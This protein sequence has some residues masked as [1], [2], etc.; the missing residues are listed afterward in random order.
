MTQTRASS[1]RTR[2]EIPSHASRTHST[3]NGLTAYP[4]RKRALV[5]H[6]HQDAMPPTETGAATVSESVPTPALPHHASFSTRVTSIPNDDDRL[7]GNST[8]D[9]EG[10][11]DIDEDEIQ[12]SSM[13]KKLASEIPVITLP[14]QQT[15]QPQ[16]T[17]VPLTVTT[18][19]TTP[20][21]V[22]AP[23]SWAVDTNIVFNSALKNGHIRLK[24]QNRRVEAVFRE[25]MPSIFYQF[26][27]KH[28]L[29]SATDPRGWLRDSLGAAAYHLNDIEMENRIHEDDAYARVL[30]DI[31]LNRTH[32]WRS[33]MSDVA[34]VA[35]GLA[36]H[37]EKEPAP[38]DRSE[39]QKVIADL[40]HFDKSYAYTFAFKSDFNGIENPREP[41]KSKPYLLPLFCDIIR[42]CF[43]S[44]GGSYLRAV[45][46]HFKRPDGGLH[47]EMPEALLA[48]SA[49]LVFAAL[50][51]LRKGQRRGAKH[52]F[53]CHL[54]QEAYDGN[55]FQLNDI[56]KR[57]PAEYPRLLQK[58]YDNVVAPSPVT[59]VS[60]PAF[61]TLAQTDIEGVNLN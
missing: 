1:R 15:E 7:D 25:A 31:P 14:M 56:K 24:I 43:E 16:S 17:S 50:D 40:M 23:D 29:P 53:L 22:I 36:Y 59:Q 57:F 52:P 39:Y 42:P 47:Y 27:T 3:S 30:C 2:Q 33:S 5:H 38:E 46:E 32:A 8:D 48:L 10:S 20:A 18:S 4:A 51:F 54:Y 12:A 55:I 21:A 61:A 26:C 60:K 58:L 37:L 6:L 35:T 11:M 34:F 13:A 49:T 19:A 9:D 44:D 41:D 28:A 45:R